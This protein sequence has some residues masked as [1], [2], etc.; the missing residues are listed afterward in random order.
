M[1]T[2][3]LQRKGSK[4]D[5]VAEAHKKE[6]KVRKDHLSKSDHSALLSV[7]SVFESGVVL[8]NDSNHSDSGDSLQAVLD[9][10]VNLSFEEKLLDENEFRR[11]K[12][13]I[14]FPE[15]R[16]ATVISHGVAMPVI[17]SEQFKERT[18]MFAR[19]THVL[20]LNSPDGWPVRF[21]ILIM[22][23]RQDH[24]ELLRYQRKVVRMMSD[25]DFYSDAR[26]AKT[27]EDLAKAV[28]DYIARRKKKADDKMETGLMRTKKFAGGFVADLKRRLPHYRSDFRDG[29]HPKTIS[30]IFM[31][32]FACLA[33]AVSFGG[34]YEKNTG[35][36]MGV[37]EVVIGSGLTMIA[38][39]LLGGSP[40]IIV[41][42]TGPV[43]YFTRVLYQLC[44]QLF[45]PDPP[46]LTIRM[47]TS[48]WVMLFCVIIG[49]SDGVAVMHY[50]TRFTDETFAAL[51]SLIFIWEAISNVI[52]NFDESNYCDNLTELAAFRDAQHHAVPFHPNSTY[53]FTSTVSTA[54]ASVAEMGGGMGMSAGVLAGG[55]GGESMGA[56]SVNLTTDPCCDTSCSL[57][58]LNLA[59]GT[60]LV[61][62]A[63]RDMRRSTY[64]NPT[65]REFIA[66]FGSAVAIMVMSGLSHLPVFHSTY[67]EPLQVASLGSKSF[68][69]PFYP[70][71][72]NTDTP[73]HQQIQAW[74]ILACA[75]PA[76]LATI[77]VF[78]EQN[79]TGRMVNSK[80]N[81]LKKGPAYNYDMVIIGVMI[82]ICGMFGF[83]WLIAATVRTL[84]HI[85]SLSDVEESVSDG[86]VQTH[87][88]RVRETRLTSLG[89]GVLMLVSVFLRD[90]LV[91]VPMPVLYGVFLYMGYTSLL[92]NQF[93]NR[94]KLIFT[95]PS[96]YPPTH[97]T[98]YVKKKVIH[99][100]TLLQLA[101]LVAL[102]LVKTNPTIQ[103]T[104]PIFIVLLIPLRFAMGKYLFKEKDLYYLDSEETPEEDEERV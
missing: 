61:S 103:I 92:S 99:L 97:Y 24:V 25:D 85:L 71:Y 76:L 33:P 49:L 69:V 102:W 1:N 36:Q 77:L 9:D 101:C 32:F 75:L 87:I 94:L 98:R 27:R 70:N 18:L 95:D 34:L 65:V 35:G 57:L 26:D 53:A 51:I 66:D 58:S 46:F 30:A 22:G 44:V 20:N 29:L 15:K 84:A 21:V 59:L 52:T 5:V 90:V 42:G 31:L 14:H 86:H 96:L 88:L 63:L 91:L 54:A 43:F 41:G 62:L 8:L 82:G 23:P 12:E 56:S 16:Y 78:L 83:P 7:K 37:L 74:H 80:D 11:V 45:G 89:I 93:F 100:F 19:L 10:L 73:A 39:A 28:D 60:F 40:M 79:I 64:L 3:D 48:F 50:C 13:V 4:V 81:K 47:Y 38:Y 17:P 55:G 6:I 2:G 68:L 67:F 72:N 104:F